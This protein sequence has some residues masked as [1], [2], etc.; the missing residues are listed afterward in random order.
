[1]QTIHLERQDKLSRVQL[2]IVAVAE[3]PHQNNDYEQL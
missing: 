1:M 3:C 2:S